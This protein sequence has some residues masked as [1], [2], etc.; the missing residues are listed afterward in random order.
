MIQPIETEYNGHR[1]RSRLEA[2]WAVFFD[3]LD[4]EYEY[5]P[6]GFEDEHGT[7]YLPDFW[8]PEHKCFIEIKGT[9]LKKRD[10]EKVLMLAVEHPVMVF[11]G[12]IKV[13]KV[14]KGIHLLSGSAAFAF[15]TLVDPETKERGGS[16][17]LDPRPFVWHE[18]D[19]G[20]LIIW[21]IP[22]NEPVMTEEGLDLVNP[23]LEK[24]KFVNSPRLVKAYRA[25]RQA[26][27]EFGEKPGTV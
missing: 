6:E 21:P 2:R 1:F 24:T 15:N 10:I 14:K 9:I 26:R 13:P 11:C 8:L 25:A 23:L 19:D 12:Q 3:A 22:A 4:V 17:M 7:R 27:F 18:R 16:M 20:S 5:E